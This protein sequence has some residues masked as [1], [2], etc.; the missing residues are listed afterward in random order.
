[1]LVLV[2]ILLSAKVF[3]N[4][5]ITTQVC[6]TKNAKISD[7]VDVQ[8]GVSQEYTGSTYL[9]LYTVY[10]HNYLTHKYTIL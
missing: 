1:M 6:I 2:N 7:L 4:S 9:L 5:A 3:S 8:Q 10:I